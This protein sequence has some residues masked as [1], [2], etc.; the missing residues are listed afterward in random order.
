[1]LNVWQCRKTGDCCKRFIST[2]PQVTK[3]EADKI[4]QNLDNPEISEHFG[5]IG[6]TK[7][8][9]RK[10]VENR[11]SLPIIKDQGTCVFLKNKECIIHQIK[12][13]VCKDYPMKIVDHPSKTVVMV[14]LECPR[15]ADMAQE[16]RKGRIPPGTLRTDKPIEVIEM[17]FYE[18]MCREKFGDE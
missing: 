14:D 6:I 5:S 16:I 2:G 3:S 13:Q 8:D 12:P 11:G 18:A 17:D 10:S 4:I 15:G 1:M 9:I 7:E